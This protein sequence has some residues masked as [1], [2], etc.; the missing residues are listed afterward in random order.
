MKAIFFLTS[1]DHFCLCT[2]SV[3]HALLMYSPHC[4]GLK[5]HLMTHNNNITLGRVS[6]DEGSV[7]FRDFYMTTYNTHNWQISVASRI[8]NLQSQQLSHQ[9]SHALDP[10]VTKISWLA[11]IR[12]ITKIQWGFTLQLYISLQFSN[13][14]RY[15]IHKINSLNVIKRYEIVYRV[16]QEERT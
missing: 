4:R 11:M 15:R 5:L 16:S 10:V 2:I 9:R 1:S 12:L 7:R 6:L 14:W 13:L 3:D 8:S